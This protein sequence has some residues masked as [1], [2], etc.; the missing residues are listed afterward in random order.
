MNEKIIDDYD[1]EKDKTLRLLIEYLAKIISNSNKS[2]SNRELI[3]ICGTS[4]ELFKSSDPHFYHEIAEAA[5]NLLIKKQYAARLKENVPVMSVAVEVKSLAGR[6]PTQTW[7]SLMQTTWQQFSTPPHIAL[8]LWHLLNCGASE[9]VLEPSAGTGSLI[10]WEQNKIYCNEIDARRRAILR[11]LEFAPTAYNAEFIDDYLP[12]EIQPDCLIMNPPFSSSGGRTALNSSKYGFRHVESALERLKRGGK[13][14]I[15]LGEAGGLDTKTGN[16][17]WR[18]LSDR[19]KIKAIIKLN[20]REYY[21]NGTTVDIN[22]VIGEKLAE[23]QSLDWNK[24]IIQI[25]SLAAQSV[26]EAFEQAQTFNLRLDR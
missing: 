25:V 23:S 9:T 18:K 13:F 26:E 10:A 16:D 14:G 19:I 4:A 8:L 5:V 20:G 15:I 6:L 24:T 17:F 11:T 21:K 7:R 12:P 1:S 3:G 2:L 22:L